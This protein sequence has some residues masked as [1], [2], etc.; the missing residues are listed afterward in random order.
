M[1]KMDDEWLFFFPERLSVH[2]RLQVDCIVARR[3]LKMTI[4]W[5][6]PKARTMSREM[7]GSLHS[8]GHGMPATPLLH[9]TRKRGWVVES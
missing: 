6:F 3:H 4:V 8:W 5:A 9:A 2:I 7:E 1:W